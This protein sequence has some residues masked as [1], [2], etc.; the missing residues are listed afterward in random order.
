M[1]SNEVN[2][3]IAKA[4]GD[5]DDKFIIKDYSIKKIS[6]I[7][8]NILILVAIISIMTGWVYYSGLSSKSIDIYSD[9]LGNSAEQ[10]QIIRQ[11]GTPIGKSITN[12]G[13][14][15]TVDAIIG[16]ET[17]AI[18]LYSFSN[19]DNN[20][21]LPRINIGTYSF[22]RNEEGFIYSSG[23]DIISSGSKGVE[24]IDI[25]TNDGII[26]VIEYF[27]LRE[28]PKGEIVTAIFNDIVLRGEDWSWENDVTELIYEGS[29]N[30]EY[31]FDYTDASKILL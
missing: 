17:T 29:W 14:T 31:L 8:K 7:S 16:D 18:V 12:N 24:I 23:T 20:L 27:N 9:K 3:E 4:I 26:E 25:D 10:I 6:K 13:I 28:L 2:Y 19:E 15:L 11:L 22:G 5:I 30:I 1:K 21:Y